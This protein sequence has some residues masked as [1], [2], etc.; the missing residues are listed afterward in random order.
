[1]AI[2]LGKKED[3]IGGILCVGNEEKPKKN[4]FADLEEENERLKIRVLELEN[5][6][7]KIR[8]DSEMFQRNSSQDA[9]IWRFM[10]YNEEENESFDRALKTID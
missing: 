7:L 4:D 3:F 1:M 2:E 6:I 8:E 5:L 10:H 9:I